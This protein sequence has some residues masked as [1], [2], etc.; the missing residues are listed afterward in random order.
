MLVPN[1]SWR[2]IPLA[3]HNKFIKVKSGQVRNARWLKAIKIIFMIMSE[4]IWILI[5]FYF[6]LLICDGLI[7]FVFI[8]NYWLQFLLPFYA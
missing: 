6:D 1:M 2:I 8:E 3:Y 4:I 5:D 7:F